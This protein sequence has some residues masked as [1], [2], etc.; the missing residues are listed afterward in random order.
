[1]E[2][3]SEDWQ[4]GTSRRFSRR[5]T[6]RSL[7]NKLST[8]ADHMHPLSDHFRREMRIF[9]MNPIEKWR[10]TGKVPWKLGLQAIKIVFVT[11]QLVVYGTHINRHFTHFESTVAFMKEM[12]L[13]N[14]DLTVDI[15][16]YPP[17]LPEA[18]HHRKEF[19]DHV[20]NAVASYS[21]LSRETFG[22]HDYDDDSVDDRIPRFTFCHES[23]NFGSIDSSRLFYNMSR[24][25]STKCFTISYTETTSQ[26]VT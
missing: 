20:D 14:P 10:A 8:C 3:A 22:A 25:V 23:Y 11:I 7:K 4:T 26:Q 5:F 21:T 24:E 13:M 6:K 18:L 16:P 19:F 2:E 17:T 1:M 12:F 9:R 15:F